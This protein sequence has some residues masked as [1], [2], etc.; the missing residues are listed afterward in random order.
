MNSILGFI[1]KISNSTKILGLN[2][3]IEAAR[4]GEAGKGFSVVAKE[5]EKMSNN[6]TDAAKE[7]SRMLEGVKEQLDRIN[8]KA[9]Q[10]A[11]SFGSQ[12]SSMEN[13]AAT[14]ENLHANI[15]VLEDYIQKL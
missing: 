14:V 13:I 8:E 9:Q 10:A 1:N 15:N 4:A 12:E 6:T 5:I 11:G 7:I 2:A 3:V